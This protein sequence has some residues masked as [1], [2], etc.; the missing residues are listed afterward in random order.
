[1]NIEEQKIRNKAELWLASDFDEET[2]KG[3]QALIDGD[4][5]ELSECFYRDL[6]FGTGGLR[7]L[8]GVGTNRMNKYTVGM[9]TQGLANY[10]RRQ[11]PDDV[12]SAVAVSYD[13]RNNSRFF[14]EVTAGVLAANGIKVYLFD[15]LR[16]TPELSFAVRH[17]RC[18]AGVMVTASHNPKEY[19]GYKAY[20]DDG[21]QVTEPHDVNIIDEVGKIKSISEVKFSGNENLITVI[22]KEIDELYLDSLAT[23]SISS[24]VIARQSD[25]KIV[26]SPLHGCGVRLVPDFLE[27]MGF[28]QVIHVPEQDVNDGNFPTVISPN[29]EE[30]SALKM[31]LDKAEAEGADL[32]MATDP[33]ADRVGIAVRNSDGHLQLLN[34]NQTAALITYYILSNRQEKGQLLPTDYIAKTIVT[35]ELL[36]VIA[37]HYSLECFDV[38]TGFKYI[39]EII[40]KNEADRR[41]ICGG[42]ESYGFLVGDYVRDKDAV[43]S[44]GIIAETAAWAKDQGKSLYDL[45]IE[46]Y[47]KFGLYS[48][49][50]LSVT[51]KGKEGAEE[52]KAMMKSFRENPPSKLDGSAIV[53][54]SDYLIGESVDMTYNQR[55]PIDSPRSDVLQFFTADGSVIS[56]RPSGTEPK[57][58]FYF[59]MRGKL[60]SKDDYQKE[61]QALDEKYERIKKDLLG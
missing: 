55:I 48:E 14:A 7:G 47:I 46:I 18:R 54:I 45:L 8:M 44:C 4:P 25:I 34:G 23:L 9:A 19:N 39:G 38:L 17:F 1:M 40:R 43:V 58:K 42:E 51:K 32:V 41:F 13:C 36:S 53:A 26:Y 12:D 57:I 33:D 35:T 22:G 6:E 37:S 30:S 21:A 15:A 50:L 28:K 20:W 27:R 10:I 31:A 52:I 24:E 2:R 61:I 5:K 3:V 16:P 11:F 49:K 59:G 60:S 29:P 56:M